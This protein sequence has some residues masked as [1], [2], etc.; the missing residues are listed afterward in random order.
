MGIIRFAIENPVKVA[1]MVILLVLFGLLSLAGLPVQLTPDVDRPVITVTT[2]WRGA[3]PQEI[4]SEIIDRQEDKLKSVTNLRK[5]TSSSTE[6]QGV[7]RLEFPVGVNKDIAYRDVSDKLRQ[8]T[9]YPAEVDEPVMSATDDEMGNVIAWMILSGG[10][11][12][13]IAPLKTFVEDQVKPILERAEGISEVNV[14]G[15]LDREIQ[16]EIDPYQ[17]AARGITFRQ[18]EDAVRRQNRNISAG[19]IA[20]GKRDYAYR[21]VGEYT[22]LTEIEDTVIAYQPGGPVLVKDVAWVRDGFKRQTGFVRSKGRFVI[23]LPARRETGANVVRAIDNLK[24]RIAAVNRDVLAP[25]GMNLELTQVYDETAYIWGAVGLVRD[26]IFVGGLLAVA[27]LWMFL[28]SLSA[29]GIIAVAIPLSVIGAFLFVAMLGRSLNVIMLAGMAFAVGNSVDNAIVVL[30]NI[31][32]HLAM[33]KK[34]LE[35]ALDGAQEVWGAVLASTLTT[36]VVYLPVIFMQEEAGQLFQ[37]I[38][39]ASVAAALLSL[40]VSILVIPPL[41]S[42]FYARSGAS[43]SEGER[44]W[45]FAVFSSR[46]VAGVHR[47]FSLRLATALGLTAAALGASW[48]LAPPAEYLPSGNKNLVFGFIISPPGYSMEEF[49]RMATLIEDGDPNDPHDGARPAWEAAPGSKEAAL[50]PPVHIPVGRDGKTIR[51]IVPPPIENF[52]YVGFNSSAF[53][54][55]TS[56]DPLNVKPLENVMT[57]IGQRLPGVFTF[58]TQTSL[59]NSGAMSSGNSVDIEVRGDDHDAVVSAASAILDAV[60]ARDYG[61]PRADPGNFAQGRPEVQIVPDREK[62][63]NLGLN[64]ADVGFIVEA[65]VEGA[66]VGEFNDRGKRIDMALTVRGARD[67]STEE[68]AQTPIATPTGKVVPLFSTA[69]LLRTTAPQQI[70]H[71]EEMDSVTL[72]VKPKLGVALQDTMREIEEEILAPLRTSGAI[73]PQVI[74]SLSGTADK[75]T[76]TLRALVGDYRGTVVRP[77][78]FG[79]GVAASMLLLLIIAAMIV[80]AAGLIGNV[81]KAVRTALLLAAV[82]GVLFLLL[83]PGLAYMLFQSRVALA[84]LVTYL[85]MAALFESFVYPLVIMF[86]IPPALLGGILGLRVVHQVSLYDVTKP[87]QQLDVLTMLGFII[88]IGIVVNNAILIVHQALVFMRRDGMDAACAVE[89]S[90]RTRT[91]PIFMTALTSVFGMMPLVVM[92][93]AGS[94][95]YRGLGSVMLGGLLLSTF[96]T[97]LVVPVVFG[98]VLDLRAWL[99]AETTGPQVRSSPAPV[100]LGAAAQPSGER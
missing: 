30:E 2:T 76:E 50:L 79:L 45:G 100:S 21:T 42:R 51:T 91:R 25:R 57:A 32:R 9:D 19:S 80:T 92:P 99:A 63:A 73:P 71:I 85:L 86:S 77:R 87:I 33:G 13:D 62:A 40:L 58:F 23:A 54:G 27:V 11:N 24:E 84:L 44:P 12:Q 96:F 64:V 20:R 48:A 88:L 52:F 3:S 60:M 14:Y 36:A 6:G 16:I 38:A 70:N 98:L 49:R 72:A 4:E 56:K 89:R 34:K 26:N 29:T 15:G 46:I 31:H 5:M 66:F 81:Q 18:V 97:L 53:M 43:G 55:C 68:I 41:A 78:L 17:L 83:N 61:Y 93:G 22:A 69:S 65:C 90:V 59:F 1:V 67:A 95:L 47:R 35:A 74:T 28:R 94:E 37:D 8:V 7:V 39:I 82:T 10:A 75:L